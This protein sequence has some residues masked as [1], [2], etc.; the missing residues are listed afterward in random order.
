MFTKMRTFVDRLVRLYSAPTR[1]VSTTTNSRIFAFEQL[2]NRYTPAAIYV[3]NF[4]NAQGSANASDPQ[5]WRVGGV[6]PAIAPGV[7]DENDEIVFTNA[8]NGA[9]VIDAV[10]AGKVKKVQLE[11]YTGTITLA[12]SL[13]TQVFEQNSGTIAGAFPIT[14]NGNLAAGSYWAGGKI[15]GDGNPANSSLIVSANTPFAMSG[16]VELEGRVI[17]NSGIMTWVGNS[18]ITAIGGGTIVNLQAG[19][20]SKPAFE[21]FATA[22]TFTGSGAFFNSGFVGTNATTSMTF[23]VPVT[24][25]RGT[26][27]S[28][29]QITFAGSA[30]FAGGDPAANETAHL[31][32]TGTITGSSDADF[33]VTG[34]LVSDVSVLDLLGSVLI[35]AGSLDGDANS[36][37]LSVLAGSAN[38][39]GMATVTGKLLV[40]AFGTVNIDGPFEILGGHSRLSDRGNGTLTINAN[41]VVDEGVIW[42]ESARPVTWTAG[43][44]TL[45]GNSSI[46]HKSGDFRVSGNG[47]R[48]ISGSGTFTN[49][50]LLEVFSTVT[51]SS[52]LQQRGRIFLT[53]GTFNVA[54]DFEQIVG[55]TMYFN[56]GHLKI[57]GEFS[58]RG[59]IFVNRSATLAAD[60]FANRG[61]LSFVDPTF[62]LE[63]ASTL[64]ITQRAVGVG[65]DF[66]QM[67]DGALIMKLYGAGGSDVITVAGAARFGGSLTTVLGTTMLI[68]EVDGVLEAVQM[69][70]PIPENWSRALITASSCEQQFATVSQ[71]PGYG[72]SALTYNSKEIV[73]QNPN[74]ALPGIQRADQN[75][76]LTFSV[77]NI[78]DVCIPNAS[79]DAMLQLSV[80]VSHGLLTLSQ[81]SNLT[82]ST[83]TGT[84][85]LEMV[86]EGTIA[87]INAALEGLVYR[88]NSNYWG[89][90]SLQIRIG[91]VPALGGSL[92]VNAAIEIFVDPPM[93]VTM[94][95]SPSEDPYAS[96]FDSGV[97]FLSHR[98]G[99]YG[100]GSTDFIHWDDDVVSA[101]TGAEVTT[102]RPMS[103]W[104]DE[105]WTGS[106]TVD[107]TGAWWSSR[108]NPELQTDYTIELTISWNGTTSSQIVNVPASEFGFPTYSLGALT[109]NDD[110]TFTFA[111]T[112]HAPRL[113]AVGNRAAFVGRELAFSAAASDDDLP[114]Q[115]LTYSLADGTSGA[116]PSGAEIDPET[117]EFTWTPTTGGT[118]TFDIVVTDDGP[119][120]LADRETISIVVEYPP[121][122]T[123]SATAS[124]AENI[125]TS[126]SV[127]TLAATDGDAPAQTV[128]FSITG[129]ADQ[130][131]FQI[132]SGQ[133]R[134]IASPN[135]EGPTDAGANN[136][137]NVEVTANDGNGGTTMQA[138]AVTVT[139]VTE[140]GVISGKV[141]IDVD[142]NDSYTSGDMN[143]HAYVVGRTVYLDLDGNGSWQSGEPTRTTGSSGE[144]EFSAASHDVVVGTTYVVRFDK[145]SI[146][147]EPEFVDSATLA[148]T[149]SSSP[150]STTGLDFGVW[151]KAPLGSLFMTKTVDGSNASLITGTA[152]E[153]YVKQLYSLLLGRIPTESIAGLVAMSNADVVTTLLLSEAEY[154]NAYIQQNYTF[155]L[156]RMASSGELSG[157]ASAYASSTLEGV[158]AAFL[159]ASEFLNDFPSNHAGNEAFVADVFR[160]VLGREPDSGS[161][162]SLTSALDSASLTRVNLINA[163]LYSDEARAN[164]IGAYYIMVL[165]RTATS[166]EIATWITNLTN[167][168]AT[169]RGALAAIL[170]ST[171]AFNH[172][173]SL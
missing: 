42:N 71:P 59:A 109:I 21:D 139:D 133:L 114:S 154:R 159:S 80:A 91:D 134:F 55:S 105:L 158:A 61:L 126:A 22:T 162:A 85:D 129:G 167:G 136:V 113:E 26:F 131:K 43:N 37:G 100:D 128:T 156:D 147:A 148:R 25:Y 17:Q 6:P 13:T 77:A 152:K 47:I 157:W 130:S 14:V 12:R 33:A 46:N 78:N 143:T 81:T 153:K 40:D 83:G 135:Y 102:V 97:T 66:T 19:T 166:T 86:F 93:T 161:L 28:E 145:L 9:C 75:S 72:F 38:F 41:V 169:L 24:S 7:S 65:G 160:K 53:S 84:D 127:I 35:S 52:A 88:P 34:K 124:V 57:Q 56:G 142:R 107:L 68:V 79:V 73:I 16:S 172:L 63:S 39:S 69:P 164:T 118:Y 110:G 87:D 18:L 104:N 54:G 121:V 163:V 45:Q 98:A 122:F 32:G 58:N 117:G 10:F 62:G 141:Y 11:G 151:L 168:T 15:S 144:Y 27:D 170:G 106:T 4:N 138:I 2:E 8:A 99:W 36:D 146:F 48:T 67:E 115:A 125:S 23:E 112:N 50:A 92:E 119:G 101:G 137:Y 5:N 108:A 64:A 70:V 20:V 123:S 155:Y 120:T 171:E 51:F 95:W 94:A 103:A 74:F 96:D 150:P 111:A 132:V 82:F 44:I 30:T 76:I 89:S 116:V 3:W 140:Y 1:R 173:S 165:G 49:N 31:T 60:K 149:V 29:G 90:E